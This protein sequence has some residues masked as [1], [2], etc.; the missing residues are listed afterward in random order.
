MEDITLCLRDALRTAEIGQPQQFRNLTAF[1]LI[2]RRAPQAGYLTLNEAIME[3]ELTINEISEGGS[4]PELII[5]N[6]SDKNVLVLDGEELLGA[7]QNRIANL[8]VLAEANSKTVLPVSCVEAGRWGYESSRA[9]ESRDFKASSRVMFHRSRAAKAMALSENLKATGTYGANQSE[10]WDHISAKQE[11]MN[12]RSSTAAMSDTFDR[13]A[14][15]VEDYTKSFPLQ[16]NQVGVV[17]AI[18]GEIEGL[19]LLDSAATFA[20]ILP[21]LVRSFAIDAIESADRESDAASAEK[22]H[23][24]LDRIAAAHADSYDGVG[25]GTDIRLSAPLVAGGGLVHEEQMIHLAAFS[26]GAPSSGGERLH[27][28]RANSRRYDRMRRRNGDH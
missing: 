4:V 21:K 9:E 26:N 27:R 15:P 7:K 24:F 28:S 20:R 11:R 13:F 22:V 2:N 14:K 1:P 18:D 23:R 19:D 6:R 25:L 12:V 16:T 5:D 17:F 8:T 3:D 10:V